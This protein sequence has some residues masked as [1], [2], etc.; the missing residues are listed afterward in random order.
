MIDVYGPVTRPAEDILSGVIRVKLGDKVY[1]LPVRSMRANREWLTDLD[2]RTAMLLG[3][4][5]VSGDDLSRIYSLLAGQP[6]TLFDLLLS[7]DTAGVLPSRAEIEALEPDASLDLVAAVREV[8]RAANPLVGMAVA[9][10]TIGQSA[11]DSSAP[12]SSSPPSTTGHPARSKR[13]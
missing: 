8:W 1:V 12:T 10:A 4:V 7:Y 2:A 11:S 13:N 3:Q 5:D 9:A 6:D